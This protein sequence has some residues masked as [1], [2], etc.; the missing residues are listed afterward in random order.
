M[1]DPLGVIS[2]RTNTTETKQPANNVLTQIDDEKTPTLGTF[3]NE[4]LPI[5]TVRYKNE[6]NSKK[7]EKKQEDKKKASQNKTKKK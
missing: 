2:S 5:F 4:S 1:E 7:S 6:K 3:I